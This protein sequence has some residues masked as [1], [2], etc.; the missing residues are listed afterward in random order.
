MKRRRHLAHKELRLMIPLDVVVLHP[1]CVF[2][3][4]MA[5][6]SMKEDE[7][8]AHVEFWFPWR[9]MLGVESEW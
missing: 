4:G 8:G 2:F 6:A 5:E 3:G 9:C 7:Q 1:I